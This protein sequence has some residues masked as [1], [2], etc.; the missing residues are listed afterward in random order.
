M[1]MNAAMQPQTKPV[2]ERLVEFYQARSRGDIDGHLSFAHPR[3]TF[4]VVGTDK[5]GPLTQPVAT[6]EDVRAAAVALFGAWDLSGVE[7]VSVDTIGDTAYVHRAG[8]VRFIPTGES[9][10]TEILEKLT[11]E[12]DLIIEYLQFADTLHLALTA[13]MAR[14]V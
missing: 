5:L 10:H 1:T 13:G 6:P 3:C 14:L 11:F 12:D 8:T 9:Y 7:T 2:Q 4:R